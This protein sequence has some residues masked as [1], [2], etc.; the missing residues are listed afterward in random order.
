LVHGVEKEGDAVKMRKPKKGWKG[1]GNRGKGGGGGGKV[2]IRVG[3]KRE[4]GGLKTPRRMKKGRH[5]RSRKK[6][7]GKE[8]GRRE[9][10]IEAVAKS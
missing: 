10:R 5:S 4:L 7:E 1:E 6:R 9:R 8:T 2:A 3:E